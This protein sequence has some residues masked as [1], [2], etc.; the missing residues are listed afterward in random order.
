[1]GTWDWDVI[2]DIQSWS[3]ETEALSGLAPG[4]FEYESWKL[5]TRRGHR[6]EW[7]RAAALK[8]RFPAWN[9]ARDV[10][11]IF[12]ASGGYARSSLVILQQGQS[13]PFILLPE[14][15]QSFTVTNTKAVWEALIGK[16]TAFARTPKYS[17]QKKGEK[18]RAAPKYRKRLGI[19]PWIELAIGTW[20]VVMVWYAV[21]S[22]NYITV[23]FM[24]LFVLG[25]YYTGLMSL[26]QGRFDKRVGSS[27]PEH[28]KPIPAAV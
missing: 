3:P 21:V 28:V 14:A 5:L 9:S 6:I 15:S 4:T 24:L 16:Q 27:N 11:A 12:N 8:E 18:S 17:V 25:Y 10:E 22:M 7:L 13:H 26:L 23:P 1:M 20:F 2:R 19:I